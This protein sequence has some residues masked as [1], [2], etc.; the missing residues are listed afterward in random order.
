MLSSRFHQVF[1]LAA[2]DKGDLLYLRDEEEKRR[3][4]EQELRE[5]EMRSFA[6]MRQK[7]EA[8][9]DDIDIAA[10]S[11]ADREKSGR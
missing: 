6:R 10:D 1:L 11:S 2:F 5:S 3:F 7:T 9:R 8:L 4:A